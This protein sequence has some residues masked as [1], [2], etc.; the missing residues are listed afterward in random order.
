MPVLCA[1]VLTDVPP[2]LDVVRPGVP[3][4]LARAVQRCLEKTPQLRMESVAEL[5]R[6]LE[7]FG[8]DA[9]EGMAVRIEANLTSGPVITDVSD[10]AKTTKLPD[11]SPTAAAWESDGASRR[12][13]RGLAIGLGGGMAAVS[14]VLLVFIARAI[15]TPSRQATPPSVSAPVLSAPVPSVEP[16][17][18]IDAGHVAAPRP[19]TPPP[20]RAPKPVAPKPI[21]LSTASSAP[22]HAF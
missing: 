6:A 4:E 18:A 8:S 12:R 1:A 16:V 21:P 2:S 20:R 11:A 13:T 19:T 17:V 5:A 14:L 10:K 15:S 3:P 9:S 22:A 7:P